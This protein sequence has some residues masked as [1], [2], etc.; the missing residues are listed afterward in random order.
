MS[1]EPNSH[2]RALQRLDARI[3]EAVKVPVAVTATFVNPSTPHVVDIISQGAYV[4][5]TP[6]LTQILVEDWSYSS[7]VWTY[8]GAETQRFFFSVTVGMGAT[9]GAVTDLIG[10]FGVDGSPVP[11]F[12][13]I[14]KGTG[15]ATSTF[16]ITAI[17]D[18]DPGTTLD[19][20]V[21]NSADTNDVNVY[22]VSWAM[23]AV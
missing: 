4:V 16:T 8:T 18:L 13:G 17:G 21:A 15:V 19:F 14:V 11:F 9:A 7:G 12:A 1:L 3:D 22:T 10:L 5:A 23:V 6:A 20:R 2:A